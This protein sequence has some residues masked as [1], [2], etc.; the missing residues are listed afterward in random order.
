[1]WA[2]YVISD[3]SLMAEC[4]PCGLK[5]TLRMGCLLWIPGCVSG[6]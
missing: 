6:Y 2:V 3:Y 1:M 5:A 4:V